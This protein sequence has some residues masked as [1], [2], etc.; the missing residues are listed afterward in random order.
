[1]FCFHSDLFEFRF[2]FHIICKRTQFFFETA[3]HQIEKNE[4]ERFIFF[5][6]KFVRRKNEI[7]SYKIENKRFNL[8]I[9]QIFTIFRRRIFHDDNRLY[10]FQIRFAN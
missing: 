5:F 8:S 9:D 3:L 2:I 7:L 6:S 10:R 4:I 1:M